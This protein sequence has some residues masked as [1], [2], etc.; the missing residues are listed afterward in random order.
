M[1]RQQS[2]CHYRLGE[3]GKSKAW[4]ASAAEKEVNDWKRDAGHG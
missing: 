1:E 2:G 3:R 4:G